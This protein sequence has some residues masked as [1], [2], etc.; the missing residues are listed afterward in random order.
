MAKTH[1]RDLDRRLSTIAGQA[2][3]AGPL[4]LPL[5]LPPSAVVMTSEKLAAHLRSSRAA[6]RSAAFLAAARNE[7][8]PCLR[9]AI[10]LDNEAFFAVLK[11]HLG[12]ELR[13]DWRQ[14]GESGV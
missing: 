12:W 5:P 7:I 4:G 10:G 1:A 8:E 3:D 6:R 9:S 13:D 2:E 11:L 14:G